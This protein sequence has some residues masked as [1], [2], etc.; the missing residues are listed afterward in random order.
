MLPNA[1]RFGSALGAALLLATPAHA[2]KTARVHLQAPV[3]IGNPANTDL[4]NVESYGKQA[5]WS[6]D[7]SIPYGQLEG[8]I[9]KQLA[10]TLKKEIGPSG[11]KKVE[12]CSDPCPDVTWWID[13]G[14]SFA[15]T[16]KGD[17]TLTKVGPSS[18][19]RVKA[20]LTTRAKARV[21]GTLHATANVPVPMP[22][23]FIMKEEHVEVPFDL[24]VEVELSASAEV[25]LWPTLEVTG[26]SLSGKIVSVS[27]DIEL[28]GEAAELGAKVGILVGSTPFGL[29]HGGPL[30]FSTM[31][32][33]IGDSAAD[34]AEAALEARADAMVRK[35]L[36]PALAAAEAAVRKA[37]EPAVAK[38][39]AAK[40][41]ALKTPLPGIGKSI[42]QL[43]AGLGATME[44]HTVTPGGGIALSGVLRM[45]NDPGQSTIGGVARVSARR[46][47]YAS[48]KGAMIPM[49]FEPI[50]TEL[51]AK[52]GQKCTVAF[53]GVTLDR[54][55]YRGANPQTA[56]GSS[57]ESRP[58]WTGDTLGQLAW[59]GTMTKGDEYYQCSFSASK[60][61][62]TAI[63]ELEL[64]ATK[65][66]GYDA[67]YDAER[68]LA[69]KIP[70]K[71]LVL[72][73]GLDPVTNVVLGGA[74]GCSKAGAT[75]VLPPSKLKE[76]ED[77]LDNC[78]QCGPRVVQDGATIFELSGRTFTESAIGQHVMAQVEAA[79]KTG[80]G[81]ATKARA[82]KTT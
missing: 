2:G 21:H 55:G 3:D 82:T 56:L 4:R 57:A 68:F 71:T 40:D 13:Y 54:R 73:H 17:P 46:C 14:S 10:D 63:V 38:A 48:F 12:T 26:P 23:G 33:V 11:K 24:F 59:E 29:L 72:D 49:G 61:P 62:N 19:N 64:G 50:N 41:D 60:L 39:N 30:A 27:A 53:S 34:K 36:D 9:A 51:E 47:M 25:K 32:A 31:L 80:G 22:V 43:T 7:F 74:Y 1:I 16:K 6:H 81:R 5:L 78:P 67:S 66:S 70:G 75:I 28:D 44:V 77:L 42:D 69:Q 18:Q 8:Q 58:T 76:L 15:F 35:G 45:P 37:L 20:Q 65:S 79:A 52:V